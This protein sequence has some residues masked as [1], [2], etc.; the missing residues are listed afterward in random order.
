M[1]TQHYSTHSQD[2]GSYLT[3]FSD[4]SIKAAVRAP[5][6]TEHAAGKPLLRLLTTYFNTHTHKNTLVYLNMK[7]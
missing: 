4:S 7:R 2:K 6:R 5:A 1:H 3:W